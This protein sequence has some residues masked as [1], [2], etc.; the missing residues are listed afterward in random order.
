[1]SDIPLGGSFEDRAAREVVAQYDAPAY[2]RRARTVERAYEDLLAR[3]GRQREEW[4]AVVRLRVGILR[5]RAGDWE[6]LRP[7]LADDAQ[8]GLLRQLHDALAPQ[9]RAPVQPTP[10]ARRLRQHLTALQHSIRG[11]NH[12]WQEYLAGVDLT[13]VNEVRARYN[14][15]YLL[16]KECALRSPAVARQGYRPLEPLRTEDIARALPPLPCPRHR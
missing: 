1:M 5:A 12:R 4:L 6:A 14:R 9:L 8:M 7:L 11:F 13:E 16:E 3:C 15:Y 10:S 2:V